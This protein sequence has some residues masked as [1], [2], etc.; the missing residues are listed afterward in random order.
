MQ[1]D[2]NRQQFLAAYDNYADAIYRHCFYRVF[3][4]PLAEELTQD[5]F[6]K[7]WKYLE[8]GKQVENLRAFLYRVAN[9]LIIDHS[10][11][12]KEERLDALLEKSA[13]LEPAYDGR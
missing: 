6:M 10:R 11:K 4:K 1:N 9:N 2:A 7:T 13:D 5:T 8:G 3:S 12:K